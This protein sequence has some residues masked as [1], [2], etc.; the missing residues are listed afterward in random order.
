[1]K[2]C[3][4]FKQLL[5]VTFAL[6]SLASALG[7]G[8]LGS[9]P[10]VDAT[11]RTT[12]PG[13]PGRPPSPAGV[14]ASYLI[15]RSQ[16]S[17][18]VDRPGRGQ[19]TTINGIAQKWT[20]VAWQPWD[21]LTISANT[22]HS[23][24]NY[25]FPQTTVT[26]GGGKFNLTLTVPW[27]FDLDPTV[28]VVTPWVSDASFEET[29][30]Y[31]FGGGNTLNFTVHGNYL[32]SIPSPPSASTLTRVQSATVDV[33][34][35]Q[36]N[37]FAWTG[38]QG[39]TAQVLLETVPFTGTFT[40]VGTGTTDSEGNASVSFQPGSSILVGNFH[41]LKADVA[42]VNSRASVLYVDN[43]TYQVDVQSEAWILLDQ[44][45]PNAYIPGEMVHLTGT[46][47]DDNASGLSGYLIWS[48]INGVDEGYQAL[49][50][51]DGSFDLQFIYDNIRPDT[52]NVTL[53]FN[54]QSGY[55]ANQTSTTLYAIYALQLDLHYSSTR[56]Y[57][58]DSIEVDGT[59]YVVTGGGAQWVPL[60]N[61]EVVLQLGSNSKIVTTDE[62]GQVHVTDFGVP[63]TNGTYQM[64]VVVTAL[65]GGVT[66]VQVADQLNQ[67]EV[68]NRPPSSPANFAWI[69]AIVV[70]AAAAVVVVVLYRKGFFKR[71]PKP[72]VSVLYGADLPMNK[73]V[74]RL[75]SL[76]E[77]GRIR[78]AMAYLFISFQRLVEANVEIVKEPSWTI[79]QFAI[80]L[81]RD[82][83]Q[84]PE[85]IYPF[86]QKI[87]DALYGG[88]VIEKEHLVD[89]F[90]MFGK[91]YDAIVHR[92][93][94]VSLS[95]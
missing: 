73:Y 9:V 50:F 53:R 11:G 38:A 65:G 31:G 37:G 41:A 20:G 24:Q 75:R 86:I 54:A 92:P 14:G 43:S 17:I 94:S 59:I 52:L 12:A 90:N 26:Y 91:I 15:M 30:L 68:E 39:L 2:K 13:T 45:L 71:K 93:L 84:S 23:G 35:K 36:W 79:R 34:I 74:E 27:T 8:S 81:V 3:A 67:I 22:S 5:V 18:T 63:S 46:L 61:R 55:T 70:P 57:T 7:A 4:R 44:D 82:K 29:A 76:Y 40:V 78:E 6:L 21:G 77:T 33:N 32:V 66:P 16:A 95:I 69:A 48:T 58:G 10:D 56:V 72:K 64:V 1:M 88:N 28:Y 80:N 47:L 49:A 19:T 25:V 42:G 83:A 60:R 51:V 85:L 89:A 62:N 87:E